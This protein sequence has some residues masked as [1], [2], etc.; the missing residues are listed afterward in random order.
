MLR[1]Q[2]QQKAL[3]RRLRC[4]ANLLQ[5]AACSNVSPPLAGPVRWQRLIYWNSLFFFLPFLLEF[6][7]VVVCF[8]LF[9]WAT[10]TAR[11]RLSNPNA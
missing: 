6:S 5:P 11:I 9:T 10:D 2:L 7:H 1:A 3:G 8:L 4:G